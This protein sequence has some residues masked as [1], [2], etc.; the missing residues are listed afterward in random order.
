MVSLEFFSDKQPLTEIEYHEYFL[1]G[2]RRPVRR[3]DYLRVPTVL[4]SG[5]LN[6]MEPS[7]FLSNL[8]V[9]HISPLSAVLA[10]QT[11]VQ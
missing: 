4:K 2:Y 9:L 1:G 6:L 3:A 10:L 8:R 5:S 11:A 7:E